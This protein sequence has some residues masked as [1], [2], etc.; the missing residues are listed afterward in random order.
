M[1]HECY[2]VVL[3]RRH[4]LYTLAVEHCQKALLF[5][6]KF[7]SEFELRVVVKRQEIF[8]FRKAML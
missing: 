2:D 6:M 8:I 4:T 1:L 5:N 3:W 7:C